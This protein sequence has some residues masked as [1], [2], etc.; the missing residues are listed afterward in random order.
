[1]GGGLPHSIEVPATSKAVAPDCGKKSAVGGGR[2]VLE[3]V[4]SKKD[5]DVFP[6]SGGQILRA[7]RT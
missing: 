7:L 2:K 6:T 4:G 5:L 3:N 1:M